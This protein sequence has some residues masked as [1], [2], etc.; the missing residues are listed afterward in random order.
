MRL[1]PRYAAFRERFVERRAN[2]GGARHT[3]EG[4]RAARRAVVEYVEAQAEA[5]GLPDSSFDIIAAVYLFHELPPQVRR[6]VAREAA[7]LLKPSGVFIEVD[8]IQY[9]DEP[10]FDILLE[11]FPRGFH[12]PYYDS[13]CREDLAAL[14]GEAGLVKTAEAVAFLTKVSASRRD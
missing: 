13:Y 9:G 5:T 6:D 14:F 2:P 10:G 3:Q 7:R 12:E 11:N 1:D 4:A 8:T